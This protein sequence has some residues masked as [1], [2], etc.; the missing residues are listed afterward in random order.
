[1]LMLHCLEKI[2]ELYEED[3]STNERAKAR[4]RQACK[5]AKHILCDS[6]ETTLTIDSLIG[7]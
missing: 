1:M 4:I 5:E 2:R 6:E 7:D 3:L